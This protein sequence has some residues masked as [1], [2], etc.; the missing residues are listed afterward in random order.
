MPPKRKVHGGLPGVLWGEVLCFLS[1][2]VFWRCRLVSRAFRALRV[3][4]ATV[5]C[6]TGVA[7]V[8]IHA[9]ARRVR[10]VEVQQWTDE[11]MAQV[12]LCTNLC[13]LAVDASAA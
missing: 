10:R 8:L 12:A 2:V 7:R 3:P 9:V 4:W 1:N 13:H 11:D 6:V 5:R